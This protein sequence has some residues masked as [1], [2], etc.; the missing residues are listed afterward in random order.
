MITFNW[1]HIITIKA[2]YDVPLILIG[3]FNSRTSTN[4]RLGRDKLVGDYACHI[5]NGTGTI[6]YVIVSIELF[7]KLFDFHVDILDKCMSDVHCPITLEIMSDEKNMCDKEVHCL[8]NNKYLANIYVYI[9]RT[10]EC[11]VIK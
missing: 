6:D 8:D 3:D 9:T 7:T 11:Y 2:K 1:W 5:S 4:S 10:I